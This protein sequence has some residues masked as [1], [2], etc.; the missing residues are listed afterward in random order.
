MPDVKVLF[1]FGQA[2][3]LND[4]NCHFKNKLVRIP[5]SEQLGDFKW[6]FIDLRNQLVTINFQEYEVKEYYVWRS[7]LDDNTSRLEDDVLIMFIQRHRITKRVKNIPFLYL[8][9]TKA[10]KY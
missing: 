8:D 3:L 7:P 5:E 10:K 4:L 1:H 9:T 6:L 2:S